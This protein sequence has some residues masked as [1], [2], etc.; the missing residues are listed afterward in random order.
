ME[1]SWVDGGCYPPSPPR[2]RGG[3]RGNPPTTRRDPIIQ[4]FEAAGLD[5]SEWSQAYN[6]HFGYWSPG[7]NPLRL[8]PMLD[9]MTE[10]VYQRL[11]ITKTRAPLVLDL[12]CGLGTAS[13]YMAGRHSDAQFIGA[14]I[15][16]WQV[17]EGTRL[18]A[19]AG[20]V[21]RVMLLEAD[22]VN[23]PYSMG[24]ADAAFAMESACYDTG[25]DKRDFVDALHGLLRP[26]GRFAV[27]DCFRRTPIPLPR[28]LEWAYRR[29]CACWALEEMAEVN[30]FVQALD[31]AG[32]EDIQVDDISWNVAPSVAHVPWTALKFIAKVVARGEI[33]TLHRERR[34]NVIAPLLGMLL[35]MARPYFSYCI[36]SGRKPDTD[37]TPQ[38]GSGEVP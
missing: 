29:C 38:P 23:L 6:M 11:D 5:Y 14:T 20:L 21:D 2:L 34:N 13:R 24:T 7:M 10:Q 31:D 25:S 37:V 16:P 33:T 1:G 15:T 17:V 28:W 9:A 12:G 35:G 19:A 18:T 27:A 26:G 22:Y 8:E 30:A 3:R 4:Y 36:V 32:F